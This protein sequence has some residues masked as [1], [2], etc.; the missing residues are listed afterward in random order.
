MDR[1]Q[2]SKIT[3]TNMSQD[4]HFCCLMAVTQKILYNSLFP[5]IPC[6]ITVSYYM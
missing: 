5:H 6:N 4:S 1:M 2:V 3:T